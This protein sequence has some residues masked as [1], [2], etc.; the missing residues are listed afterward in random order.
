MST[1]AIIVEF[2]VIG[3][4]VLSTVIF[5]IL[6]V[7]KISNLSF[8]L[9]IK[10]LSATF[11]LILTLISYF[12]GALLN[13]LSFPTY[14]F[15]IKLLKST[16]KNKFFM[17]LVDLRIVNYLLD[18][19]QFWLEDGQFQLDKMRFF[20]F[21]N[22]SIN[23]IERLK[24]TQSLLRL[25]K[26]VAIITP[27]FGISFSIWLFTCLNQRVTALIPT[28]LCLTLS[29]LSTIAAF[30]QDQDYRREMTVANEIIH[31]K[32]YLSKK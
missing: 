1:T 5:L 25:F 2:L 26:G 24:Y 8:L 13:H 12:L 29:L 17:I 16:N 6:T 9:E 22:G 20:I 4:L 18:D 14:L 15:I 7:L 10:E 11:G 23:L 32:L 31:E 19:G 30:I 3:S 27:L 21:E 28:G